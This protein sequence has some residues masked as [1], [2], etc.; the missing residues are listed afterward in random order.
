MNIIRR[1]VGKWK[2]LSA[3]EQDSFGTFLKKKSAKKHNRKLRYATANNAAA[4]VAEP[5]ADEGGSGGGF[6]QIIG[7]GSFKIRGG[8]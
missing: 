7:S 6:Q 5:E 1:V 4:G 8:F 3:D 2:I